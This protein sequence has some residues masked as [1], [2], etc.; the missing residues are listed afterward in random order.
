MLESAGHESRQ[1]AKPKLNPCRIPFRP[2]LT[3]RREC[4][5]G[6][7]SSRRRLRGGQSPSLMERLAFPAAEASRPRRF[8]AGRREC[9]RPLQSRATVE[10]EPDSLFKGGVALRQKEI[11]AERPSHR[12]RRAGTAPGRQ[13]PEEHLASFPSGV[14]R[15]NGPRFYLPS[16]L[17]LRRD[18]L[19]HRGTSGRGPRRPYHRLR[20][21]EDGGSPSLRPPPPRHRRGLSAGPPPPPPG[22][23]RKER[24]GPPGTSSGRSGTGAKGSTTSSSSSWRRSTPGGSESED[25]PAGTLEAPAT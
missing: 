6:S 3:G 4:G 14:H 8:S 7:E 23:R 9:S 15:R 17:T 18:P 5:V 19:V 24:V 10:P 20:P 1:G 11:C 22:R 25:P 16:P 13:P 12:Q 21:P 2:G